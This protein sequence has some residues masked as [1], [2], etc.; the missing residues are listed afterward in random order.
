M[1]LQKTLIGHTSVITDLVVSPCNRYVI[2]SGGD[3]LIIVWDLTTG[4]EVTRLNH[5]NG[6]QINNIKFA[7]TRENT[8]NGL[9]KA[10][11]LVSGSDEGKVV[12]YDLDTVIPSSE[13][14]IQEER[15]TRKKSKEKCRTRQFV[16]E[17]VHTDYRF[18]GRNK[19]IDSVAMNKDGYVIGGSST[20]EMFVWHINLMDA[21]SGKVTTRFKSSIKIHKRSIHICEFNPDV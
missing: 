20:G 7:E 1:L 17:L 5:H 4:L 9:R 14:Q 18:Q 8:K 11:W 3:G 12:V 15:T 6:Q 21:Q 10:T 16:A 2:S 19:K 13:D